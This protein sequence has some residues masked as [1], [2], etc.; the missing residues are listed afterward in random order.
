MKEQNRRPHPRIVNEALAEL[1][2]GMKDPKF[3]AN[4]WCNKYSLKTRGEAVQAY[5]EE[6]LGR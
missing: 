1:R 2:K 6:R 4:A 5:Y 3:D